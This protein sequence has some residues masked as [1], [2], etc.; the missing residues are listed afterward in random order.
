LTLGSLAERAAISKPVVYEHFGTRSG[1]LIALYR[2]IDARQVDALVQAVARAPK[3]LRDVARIVAGA[4]MR[5]YA[6]VGPEWHAIS[7]ALQGDEEMNAAQL[8]MI[9]GYVELYCKVLS[10]FTTLSPSDLR[11][12]CVAILGAAE[13]ISRAM[14]QRRTSEAKATDTL[15]AMIVR[16]IRP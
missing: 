2:Q 15:A 16:A 4:Y 3:R 14:I 1:L 10:P 12:R 5:C 13:A 6:E 7:A 11:L 8:E 9:D